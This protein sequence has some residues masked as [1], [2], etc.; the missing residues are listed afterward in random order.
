LNYFNPAWNQG[1]ANHPKSMADV[2][3]MIN[4][5]KSSGPFNCRQTSSDGVSGSALIKTIQVAVAS[6]VMH[7]HFIHTASAADFLK[8]DIARVEV[9]P[10]G[11]RT[12][13]TFA[14][15]RSSGSYFRISMYDF[16]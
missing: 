4:Q 12:C 9:G 15:H 7:R 5:A 14:R 16:F 11:F 3:T 6:A 8:A 2:Q 10:A 1:F 13:P